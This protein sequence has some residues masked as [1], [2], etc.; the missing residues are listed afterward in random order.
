MRSGTWF[1][2]ELGHH[3]VG[4]VQSGEG[5]GQLRADGNHLHYGGDHEGEEE[6]VLQIV[7]GG[8]LAS[9]QPYGAPRYMTS[10]PTGPAA[11]V[12]AGPSRTERS[13]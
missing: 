7:A 4:A 9:Q 2:F 12:E 5:F 13:G 3:F 1:F 8:P 6:D 11:T 10:A